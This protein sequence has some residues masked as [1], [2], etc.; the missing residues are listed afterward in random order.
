LTGQTAHDFLVLGHT[1]ATCQTQKSCIFALIIIYYNVYIY[2]RNDYQCANITSDIQKF[3]YLSSDITSEIFAKLMA[4]SSGMPFNE[5]FQLYNVK[6]GAEREFLDLLMIQG[7]NNVTQVG[8]NH[9]L[10]I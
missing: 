3:G 6:T 2:F 8:N 5:A 1:K 4:N 7:Q 10:K 9:L